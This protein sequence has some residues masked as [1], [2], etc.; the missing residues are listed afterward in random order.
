[1]VNGKL[2]TS[3]SPSPARNE[4]VLRSH[5]QTMVASS[6]RRSQQR[7]RRRDSLIPVQSRQFL[8]QVRLAGQIAATRWH[9]DLDSPAAWL[10]LRFQSE[11]SEELFRLLRPDANPE[12]FFDTF[13]TQKKRRRFRPARVAVGDSGDRNSACQRCREGR[14]RGPARTR[15]P[16]GSTPLSNRCDASLWSPS[17]F[18]VRRMAVGSK[19]ALSSK[20]ERVSGLTS[21]SAPPITP[22]NATGTS[23]V[24]DEQ[25]FR[26]EIPFHAVES[27]ELFD[28]PAPVLT[29]IFRVG[30]RSKSKACS[31]CPVSSMT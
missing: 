24:A 21:E 13:L 19:L 23:P 1:M 20:M 30:K 14:P 6:P 7:Q 3:T 2:T 16:S 11:R 12:D 17:R 10:P 27:R 29:T 22:A 31:G 28:L 5:A 8:D 26:R 4:R 25:I 18:A 15:V 9:N